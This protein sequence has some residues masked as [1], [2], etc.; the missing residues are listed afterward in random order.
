M[1][2][3]IYKLRPFHIKSCI[4]KSEGTS[5]VSS[6]SL[7]QLTTPIDRVNSRRMSNL[8]LFFMK[9]FYFT[10]VNLPCFVYLTIGFKDFF[11]SVVTKD[12]RIR[13]DIITNQYNL[14]N[15]PN[16]VCIPYYSFQG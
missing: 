8:K 7:L 13:L 15:E 14:N 3:P 11:K 4:F 1:F 6:L 16:R 9:I 12:K 5:R 2:L 10:N